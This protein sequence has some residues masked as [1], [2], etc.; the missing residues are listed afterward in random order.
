MNIYDKASKLSD[1]FADYQKITDEK[2]EL[3]QR[4]NE[5]NMDIYD[6]EL[7][8]IESLPH[9]IKVPLRRALKRAKK[10]EELLDLYR[11]QQEFKERY[12]TEVRPL[13]RQK[14]LDDIREI[15]EEIYL[16]EEELEEMN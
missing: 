15:T 9:T 6:K 5:N 2:K 7:E 3:K 10:V 16:K 13:D 1:S 14:T 8:I 12:I 11:L 4:V